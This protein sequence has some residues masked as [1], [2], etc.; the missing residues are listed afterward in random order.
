MSRC[1][2]LVVDYGNSYCTSDKHPQHGTTTYLGKKV[3]KVAEHEN[4]LSKSCKD[5]GKGCPFFKK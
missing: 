2:Y 4:R 3:A 1:L 5:S